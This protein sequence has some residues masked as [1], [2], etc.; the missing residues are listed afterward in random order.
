MPKI[1]QSDPDLLLWAKSFQKSFPAEAPNLGFSAAE[2]GAVTDDLQSLIYV[3]ELIPQMRS[4]LQ[5]L[6]SYK[7]LLRDGGG[8]SD[9]G[10]L[11]E[12]SIASPPPKAVAPGIVARLTDVVQ[13]ASTSPRFTEAMG[14]LLGISSPQAQQSGAATLLG[15]VAPKAKTACL[16]SGEVRIEFVRG[17]SDGVVVESRRGGETEWKHLAV[18]RFSPY[19]DTR[20]PLSPGQPE[21]REYRLRYLD[22]DEPVGPYSDLIVVHTMP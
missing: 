13:R 12:L 16:P 1:P 2:I 20:P 5:E 14:K 9:A 4:R 18:D 3:L 22:E 8:S 10:A 19:V 21:R 7:N 17:D 15:Q 11:P 6:T